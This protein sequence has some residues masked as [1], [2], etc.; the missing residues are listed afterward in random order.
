MILMIIND[1]KYWKIVLPQLFHQM[2]EYFPQEDFPQ[3]KY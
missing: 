2:F 3:E 1:A